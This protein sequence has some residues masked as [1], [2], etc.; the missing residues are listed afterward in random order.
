MNDTD[1]R[2]LVDA[3]LTDTTDPDPLPRASRF[4]STLPGIGSRRQ[5]ERVRFQA[6]VEAVL[7][8]GRR[9]PIWGSTEDISHRGVFVTA[10]GCPP[11]IESPVALRIHTVHG[12]LQVRARVVH[13]IESVGF[14][15]EFVDLDEGQRIALGLLVSTRS[16]AP[17][18]IRRIVH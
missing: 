13:S 4:E 7:L 5:Q 17:G 10:R 12:V 16:R 1:P 14:G 11:P 8:E 2:I 3:W 9:P 6:R 18:R 15:C